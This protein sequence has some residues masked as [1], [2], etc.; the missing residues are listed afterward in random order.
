MVKCNSAGINDNL[1]DVHK[2]G[3]GLVA[4]EAAIKRKPIIVSNIG[5]LPQQVIHGKTGYIANNEAEAARYTINL[6]KDRNLRDN[7]G[8][9]ARKYVLSKFVTPIDARNMINLFIDTLNLQ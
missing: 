5:G 7:F 4:S 2:E 9:E 6:L 3:F 8:T 1:C